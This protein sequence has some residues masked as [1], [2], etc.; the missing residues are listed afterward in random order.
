MSAGIN[1]NF[2][3]TDAD[4]I[5]RIFGVNWLGHFYALNQLYPLIRKTS[6]MPDTPAPRIIWEAS[7]NHRMARQDIHFG[8]LEEINDPEFGPTN[9]YA[10]S[11]LAII[12]GNK[13]GLVGKV[14]QPNG[15]NI[16]AVTLHPG[17]VCYPS[18][19]RQDYR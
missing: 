2:Y 10:R 1:V 13:F 6:K 9:Y 16:F 3:D 17:M 5:E 8:S 15:D 4:G 7:E 19:V 11:K 12:L 14:I 18:N